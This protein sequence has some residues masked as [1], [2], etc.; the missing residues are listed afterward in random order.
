MASLQSTE[1]APAILERARA[2][3]VLAHEHI[4]KELAKP[5]YTLIRRLVVRPAIAEELLQDAFVEIFC[6][7]RSYR[8][9]GSFI[10]WVRSIAVN[11]SLMYLRSPWHRGLAWIGIDTVVASNH[12]ATVGVVE[13]IDADLERALASLPDVSRAVV[14][15]YDVEEMTHAEIAQLFNRTTSFSKA[16]LARAHQQLRERLKPV[17]GEMTCMRISK[18]F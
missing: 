9:S 2:G 15:L 5:V 12:E 18:T 3:D 16:Q 6:S 4:Y 8:G 11:K 1:I 17:S 7:M 14:W 13:P 10:G